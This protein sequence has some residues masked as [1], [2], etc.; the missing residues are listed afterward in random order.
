MKTLPLRTQVFNNLALL[1]RK[2]GSIHLPPGLEPFV[3]L[4]I[5]YGLTRRISGLGFSL[6]FIDDRL[7]AGTK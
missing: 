3:R 1:G 7:L 5:D 4:L 2:L 6:P